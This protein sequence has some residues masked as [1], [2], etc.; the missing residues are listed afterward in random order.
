MVAKFEAFLDWIE[1]RKSG[2]LWIGRKEALREND[3]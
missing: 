2:V 3:D 1:A